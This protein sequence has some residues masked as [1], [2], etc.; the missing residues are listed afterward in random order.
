M[1]WIAIQK[2]SIWELG[3]YVQIMELKLIWIDLLFR[4]DQFGISFCMVQIL[5][6]WIVK[7]SISN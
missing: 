5:K 2:R 7:F 4:N 1:N 3:L 6:F